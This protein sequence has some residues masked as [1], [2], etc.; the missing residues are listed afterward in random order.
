MEWGFLFLSVLSVLTVAYVTVLFGFLRGLSALKR[1]RRVEFVKWPSV[2]VVLP[3]RNEAEV[4]ERTLQSLM[5][6]DYP[7]HWDVIVVDD[8]SDDST[9]E[10]LHELASQFGRLRSIRV[11][12]SRPQ[13]PKKHALALGIAASSGEIIVTTDADC[14]YDA[15]WLRCL[16]TH[17]TPEVGVVA[18]ITVFDLEGEPVPVWQSVQWLD[19]FVQNFLAAGAIGAGIAGSCNGS[20]LAYRREVYTAISGFGE[21]NRQVSGDD[22]LFAQRV[23][24]L[25]KWRMAFSIDPETTVKSLPVDSF[26]QMLHQRLRWASKGLAYRGSM[27][28]FLFGVYGYY[29]LIAAAPFVLM[30]GSAFAPAVA[31][32]IAVKFCS[33]IA[34]VSV[35]CRMFRQNRLLKYFPLYAIAH[36]YFTPIFGIGGLLM[37]YRWKGDWYR[38][39]RLPRAMRKRMVRLRRWFRPKRHPAEAPH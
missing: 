36:T 6:Q 33:D 35:A 29:L 12:G 15:G 14:Q 32:V 24:R 7:G 25:S 11:S 23:A 1:N 4:L 37:P 8:R 27:L 19:F 3:A 20:N 17:M 38:S 18:G 10:I 34:V 28:G 22:V 26:A 30:A 16:V 13:S 5:R 21:S 2:S 9:P 39:S 31:G